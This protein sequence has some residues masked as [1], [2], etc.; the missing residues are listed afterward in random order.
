MMQILAYQAADEHLQ[1]KSLQIYLILSKSLDFGA[2]LIKS[3]YILRKSL[4]N[5]AF[6]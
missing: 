1:L 5:L 3:S 4:V 2:N 6:P